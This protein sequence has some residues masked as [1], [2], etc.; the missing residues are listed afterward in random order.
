M[1]HNTPSQS[2]GDSPTTPRFVWP[3]P[4]QG[5]TIPRLGWPEF[6]RVVA[7]QLQRDYPCPGPS[8]DPGA[9]LGNFL[10]SHVIALAEQAEALQAWDPGSHVAHAQVMEEEIEAAWYQFVGDQ[11]EPSLSDDETAGLGG[12]PAQPDFETDDGPV[13]GWFSRDSEDETFLN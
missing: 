13:R 4:D 2:P 5:H 7:L 9:S 1:G 3:K 10:A 11:Y 6:L 12:H 8:T